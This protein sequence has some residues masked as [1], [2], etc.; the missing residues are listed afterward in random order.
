MSSAIIIFLLLLYI[1]QQPAL[2]LTFSDQAG[3]INPIQMLFPVGNNVPP[4]NVAN[5]ISSVA[6]LLSR[7]G[8][9]IIFL[10]FFLVGVYFFFNLLSSGWQYIFSSGNAKSIEAATSRLLNAILGLVVLLCSFLIIRLISD[11]LNIRSLV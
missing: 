5:P 7:G 2:A 4:F 9:N 1:S 11:I 3:G 10:L 8:I 6:D